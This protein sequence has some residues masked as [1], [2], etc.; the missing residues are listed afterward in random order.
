MKMIKAIVRPEKTQEVVDAL[1]AAGFLALTR[2]DVVGRGKQGGLTMGEIVYDEL[3]KTLLLLV[4]ED[5]AVPKVCETIMETART[6]R[7]GD[8]KIFVSPVKEVFTI[9][10]GQPEL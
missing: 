2:I 4:V 10:T 6:G 3:P 5:E 1:E 8:G 7:F 9:R